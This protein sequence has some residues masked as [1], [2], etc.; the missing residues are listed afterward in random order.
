MITNI[1]SFWV[2]VIRQNVTKISLLQNNTVY[3]D[4]DYFVQL[5]EEYYL[6]DDPSDLGNFI[7]GRLEFPVDEGSDAEAEDEQGEISL[8]NG[9]WRPNPYPLN[10]ATRNKISFFSVDFQKLGRFWIV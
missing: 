7:N 8:L 1:F 3:L 10:K 9:Q 6:S 5:F 4:F 2:N